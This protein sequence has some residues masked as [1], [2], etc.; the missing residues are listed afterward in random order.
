M[1][2]ITVYEAMDGF[3]FNKE[4]DC[5]KYEKA[6]TDCEVIMSQLPKHPKGDSNFVNGEGWIQHDKQTFDRVW[7]TFYKLACQLHK[8]IKEY[9]IG[10]YGFG[11][12]LDDSISPLYGY[13]NRY[14]AT[15]K[16]SL[17]E[18]GQ[19]YFSIY[20]DQAKGKQINA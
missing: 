6:I 11:R 13:Y 18:Y 5:E 2:A 4:S 12:T 15:N 17:R 10:S 7:N 9:P 20:E 19:P 1:K 8:G 3:R 14:M 16:N